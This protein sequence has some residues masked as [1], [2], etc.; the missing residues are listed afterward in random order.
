MTFIKGLFKS[1]TI[2]EEAGISDCKDLRNSIESLNGSASNSFIH[3]T[4][5]WTACSSF[6]NLVVW[7][8]TC[9]QLFWEELRYLFILFHSCYIATLFVFLV[10]VNNCF[11]FLSNQPCLTLDFRFIVFS[12][13]KSI[14]WHKY[15]KPVIDCTKCILYFFQSF[16][17]LFII[18]H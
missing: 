9:F 5:S 16:G 12:I 3:V 7:H 11:S 10:V 8:W 15:G 18:A 4:R 13:H 6:F 17:N 2:S 14:G 1:S